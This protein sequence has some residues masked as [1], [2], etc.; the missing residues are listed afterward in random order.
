MGFERRAGSFRKRLM[1]A[2]APH[3]S[4]R[5]IEPRDVHPGAHQ[6]FDHLRGIAGGS[7]VHTILACEI[8][9]LYPNPFYREG[10]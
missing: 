8:S 5:K 7:R 1:A 6:A 10:V 9:L 4:L 2:H 3:E